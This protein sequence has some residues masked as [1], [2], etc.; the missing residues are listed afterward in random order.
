MQ[1]QHETQ[2]SRK[3]DRRDH[4]VRMELLPLP[5]LEEIARVYT[6]GAE[7]YGANTWQNLPDAYAR[8]KGAL[9]RHLTAIDK[10]QQRD[11][12]TG[13][14]HAAQVAWNAIAML[15]TVLKD[16]PAS[17]PKQPY[18][19]PTAKPYREQRVIHF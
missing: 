8:Y 3:N 14:L 5:E 10:G 1:T 12:D 9:L 16:L 11:P 19:T 18:E 13:C 2:L 15:H 6:V 7:K 17:A 4:K